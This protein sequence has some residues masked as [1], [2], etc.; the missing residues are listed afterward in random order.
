MT[1]EDCQISLPGKKGVGQRRLELALDAS[2]DPEGLVKVT[3]IDE[4]VSILL[5]NLIS[6]MKFHREL[7]MRR[8]DSGLSGL[9]FSQRSGLSTS[10]IYDFEKDPLESSVKTVLIYSMAVGW[11]SQGFD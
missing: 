9:D 10:E 4:Q 3:Q 5:R 2:T 1:S 8:I 6:V 7:V 11:T